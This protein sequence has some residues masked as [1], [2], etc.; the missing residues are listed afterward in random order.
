MDWLAQCQENVRYGILR[1]GVG[2][3]I[4]PVGQHYKV[5]MS[6]QSQANTHADIID[7]AIVFRIGQV[8]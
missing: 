4:F 3:L 6:T 8:I 7:A 5:A 2:K 1:H